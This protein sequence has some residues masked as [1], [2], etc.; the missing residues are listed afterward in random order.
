MKKHLLGIFILTLWTSAVPAQDTSSDVPSLADIIGNMNA[1]E[2]AILENSIGPDS[3]LS[4]DFDITIDNIVAEAIEEGVISADEATDASA[5]LALV[6]SNAEYFNFDI[7]DVIGSVIEQGTYSISQVRNTLEGFNTLSDTGKQI[8]GRQDFDYISAVVTYDP[9]EVA[10]DTD[11]GRHMAASLA[12][13]NQLSE[14][15][16]AIVINQMPILSEQAP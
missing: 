13:W 14:A 11:E 5:T 3:A 16:K 9:I 10:N 4:A 6:S 15:D 2:L 12:I 8:V 1:S 7:L